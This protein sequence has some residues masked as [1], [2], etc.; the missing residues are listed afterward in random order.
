MFNL[1]NLNPNEIKQEYRKLTMSLQDNPQQ[2]ELLNNEYNSIIN[3][4][5]STNNINQTKPN[6][7]SLSNTNIMGIN[8]P[9]SIMNTFNQSSM[10]E[11]K[12][13]FIPMN[14]E[15]EMKLMT[16]MMNSMPDIL[17]MAFDMK[18]KYNSSEKEKIDNNDLFSG[19]LDFLN[20]NNEKPPKFKES[21]ENE[22]KKLEDVIIEKVV[23]L[24]DIAQ[25]KEIQI[26]YKTFIYHEN[27]I[28]EETSN[29]KIVKL[30]QCLNHNSVKK[31][32]YDGNKYIIDKINTDYSNLI[33][34]F[35]IK[36][37]IEK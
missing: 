24:Y 28:I 14:P 35:K 5:S 37:N 19:F 15:D 12:V 16:N 29:Y 8:N 18:K 20:I 33:I 23:S 30:N 22:I 1:F 13:M 10:T 3:N 32:P 11:P 7:S 9:S 4:L 34:N 21:Q 31:F 27:K 2:L 25:E 36:E 17:N 26:N 6:L